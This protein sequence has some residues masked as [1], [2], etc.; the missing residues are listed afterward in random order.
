MGYLLLPGEVK[1]IDMAVKKYSAIQSVQS[2]II[3]RVL[4]EQDFVHEL[5]YQS[6]PIMFD[7]IHIWWSKWTNNLLEQLRI[8]LKPIANDFRLVPWHIVILE[9]SIVV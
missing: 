9:N 6:C 7:G 4:P 2:F 5:T 3:A 1:Q 8:F